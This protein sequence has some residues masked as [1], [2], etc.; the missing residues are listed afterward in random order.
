MKIELNLTTNDIPVIGAIKRLIENNRESLGIN[1]DRAV[2]IAKT[3]FSEVNHI[4]SNQ[5]ENKLDS[6]TLIHYAK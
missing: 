3:L 4:N 6:S 2:Q 1:H 5:Y